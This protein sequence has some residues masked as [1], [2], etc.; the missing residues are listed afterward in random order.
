M[1]YS[2][3]F[4]ILVCLF[5]E[6]DLFTYLLIEAPFFNFSVFIDHILLSILVY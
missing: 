2:T 4:P 3:Y 1:L 5:A 6:V